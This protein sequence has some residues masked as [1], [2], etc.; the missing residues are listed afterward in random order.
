MMRGRVR[1]ADQPESTGFRAGGTLRGVTASV[2]RVYL[3]ASLIAPG[4]SGSTRPTRL[5]QG[6]SRPP[7]RPSGRAALSFTPPL[8][9]QGDGGLS[10]PSEY[11]SA[12]RHTSTGAWRSSCVPG[13][14]P[15]RRVLC[16][17]RTRPRFSTGIR[18]SP[19]GPIAPG[20]G[21]GHG[22]RRTCRRQWR[23]GSAASAGHRPRSPP[24]RRPRSGPVIPAGA[25]G[26]GPGGHPLPSPGG[27]PP[28]Q[29]DRWAGAQLRVLAVDLIREWSP[30]GQ[31]A[32]VGG[33]AVG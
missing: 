30:A 11:S 21:R 14:H 19:A 2:P 3:P 5:C 18:P 31:A 28:G 15:A 26:A 13:A 20:R 6:C 12:S 4:P 23:G 7:R 22:R 24:G 1:A 16:R 8:R 9:R 29:L 17:Q 32:A 27:R 25:L 10:P 33:G